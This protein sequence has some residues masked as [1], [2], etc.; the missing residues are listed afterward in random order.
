M[1]YEFR[2]AVRKEGGLLIALAGASGSG[3]TYSALRLARGLVGDAGK[4]AGVDTEAGRML[5]YADLFK[6]DHLHLTPP[7]R[8]D[9]YTNAIKAA[10]AAG[11][12]AIIIDS[13]S[14]EWAGE[15]GILDWQEEEL[16]R[17]AGDD[18]KKR[19]RVKM[20]SWIKPK[21]GHK[22]MVSRML[23]VKAHLIFCLRA[24]EKT[25]IRKGPDGKTLIVPLGYQPICEKSFMFEMTMS[26]LLLPDKPGIPQPIKLQEQHRHA[27]P[28]GQPI[29]EASGQALAEW[30]RGGKAKETVL[31]AEPQTDPYREWTDKAT[32]YITTTGTVEEL[33]AWW[34][35]NAGHINALSDDLKAEVTAAKDARKATLS[36]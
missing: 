7:F 8:P 2:P 32:A 17:M 34:K 18:W 20:A 31:D 4:V 1:T 6:Y 12:G 15:G 26:A 27:F 11:Y 16:T 10:D 23:Q 29:T 21:M 25:D 9:A 14:H 28:D 3:K 33:G 5:H 13:A 24:E 30:A 36:S 35:N 19:E 22:Q